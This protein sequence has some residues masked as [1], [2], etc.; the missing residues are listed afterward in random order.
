MESYI[1]NNFYA[2]GAPMVIHFLLGKRPEKLVQFDHDCWTLMQ[3]C[4][5]GDPPKRPLLGV[6]E[7]KLTEIMEKCRIEEQHLR[8]AKTLS[9]RNLKT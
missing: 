1:F 7:C 4:W 2:A 8:G 3:S 9:P 5:N 6:V